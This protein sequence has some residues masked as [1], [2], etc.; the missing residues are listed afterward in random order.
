MEIKEKVLKLTKARG[1][2]LRRLAKEAGISETAVYNWYNEKNHT[3]SRDKIEDVCAAFG[4]S[5]AEFYA[6]LEEDSFSQQEIR[7]L[8]LF[9]QVPEKKKEAVLTVVQSFVE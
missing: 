2:S 1:W 8:E 7:L 9:R 4:I 3:P 5:V 6:D